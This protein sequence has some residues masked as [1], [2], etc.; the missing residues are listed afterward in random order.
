MMEK[1]PLLEVE[2]LQKVYGGKK[3]FLMPGKKV[4]AVKDVNFHIGKGETFGLIGESGSGK[5]TVG[6]MILRLIEPTSGKILYNGRSLRDLS[7]KEMVKLRNEVQIVFQD[8]GSAFNPRQTIGEQI[9]AGLKRFGENKDDGYIQAQV[10]HM[11]ERVG[12][13]ADF[14][15]RYPHELS[16]GQRQRAGIARA[17]ILKPKF[18]VLD[19][20]V[21]ALDVSVKAQIINLL[22]DLQKEFELTYLFI[23]HNLDLVAYFCDRVAVL[24][25]GEVIETSP[26]IELFRNP[27][28]ETTKKLLSSMLTL[29]G[30]LGEVYQKRAII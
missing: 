4:T 13:R 12:L 29:D 2:G 17:L 16:G 26:T 6:R 15:H 18:L 7:K 10:L 8:S 14:Y 21:S 30:H 27:K 9:G 28:H 24:S 25:K 20:P 5:T 1:E 19:E 3:S 11:L 22:I 23:A